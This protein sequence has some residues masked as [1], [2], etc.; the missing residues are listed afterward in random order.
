MSTA[1]EKVRKATEESL[2]TV[3]FLSIYGGGGGVE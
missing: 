1:A 3:V 2:R